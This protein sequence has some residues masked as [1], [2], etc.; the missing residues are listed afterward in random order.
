MPK[1]SLYCVPYNKTVKKSKNGVV[2]H[3]DKDVN[4]QVSNSTGNESFRTCRECGKKFQDA[5][6]LKIHKTKMQHWGS[7]YDDSE[8]GL[9]RKPKNKQIPKVVRQNKRRH[10]SESHKP[11]KRFAVPFII[12]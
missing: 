10:S 8:K 11:T 5:R 9:V 2:F 12:N 6:C 7:S 4:T 1:E 3:C